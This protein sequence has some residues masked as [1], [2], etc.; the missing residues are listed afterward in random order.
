MNKNNFNSIELCYFLG[1]FMIHIPQVHMFPLEAE[2]DFL[3]TSLCYQPLN[4]LVLHTSHSFGQ[5][6]LAYEMEL[7][8]LSIIII[9]SK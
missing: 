3:E 2:P 9:L 8:S 6:W 4:R 1:H 5:W 7:I